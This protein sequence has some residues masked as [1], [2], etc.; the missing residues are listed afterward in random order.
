MSTKTLAL[1]AAQQRWDW[2]VLSQ[3]APP[4][5]L[6]INTRTCLS[7]TLPVSVSQSTHLCLTP[8]HTTDVSSPALPAATATMFKP[9]RAIHFTFTPSPQTTPTS[10]IAIYYHHY[11]AWKPILILPANDPITSVT[12]NTADWCYDDCLSTWSNYSTQL[13]ITDYQILVMC[14]SNLS[15]YDSL[16]LGGSLTTA[17]GRMSSNV[18]S[19]TCNMIQI[20]HVWQ[21][22]SGKH[23]ACCLQ[24]FY[25]KSN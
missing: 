7:I 3:L 11:S 25:N 22:E 13:L 8:V 17:N 16:Q 23:S 2:D 9:L 12:D 24:Q 20:M 4:H 10:T 18:A 19:N 21:I 14:S 1:W 6:S 5:Y 15:G